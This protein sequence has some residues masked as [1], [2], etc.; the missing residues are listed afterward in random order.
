MVLVKQTLLLVAMPLGRAREERALCIADLI[1][2]HR[3]MAICHI[4][5]LSSIPIFSIVR[6]GFKNPRRVFRG[7]R[8]VMSAAVPP[9]NILSSNLTKLAEEDSN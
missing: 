4:V 9:Y 6:R 2:F 3:G 8:N 7:G 1:G 5:A